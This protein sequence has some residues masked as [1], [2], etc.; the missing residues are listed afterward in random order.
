MSAPLDPRPLGIR[1]LLVGLLD[2]EFRTVVTTRLLPIVYRV[3][4][5][6]I[7]VGVGWQ[8]VL[9]FSSSW[10]HGTLWLFVLGPAILVGCVTVVRVFLELVI[11]I[12]RI[13]VHVEYVSRRLVDIADQTEEI[14]TDLPRI[15][16]WRRR[17]GRR[18]DPSEAGP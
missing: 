12:F 2:L 14:A 16:F 18:D 6:A 4:V 11:S 13:A 1:D 10:L 9:G 5:A 3:A 8:V 15:Q 7:V 17:G